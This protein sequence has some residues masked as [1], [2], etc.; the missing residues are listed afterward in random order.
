MIPFI[1]L[2]AQ[3]ALIKDKVEANFRRVLEHGQFIMGPEI[4][5]CEKRLADFAGARHCLTV[6][7]GTDALLVPLMALGVGPGDAVFVPSFTF[8]ATVEVVLLLGA[9]PVYVD[10]DRRTF[11]L[12]PAHLEA[13]IAAIRAEGKVRPRAVISVDLFGLPADYAAL[14]GICQDAE[15]VLIADAAQSFGGAIGN[16]RVGTLAPIT[17][18]SFFPAKPLGCYGDGG[19]VFTD[20]D[21]LRQTMASIRV[22]GQGK[23]KYELDRIGLNARFDTMQAAVILAKLDIFEDELAK[24][25]I[26]AARYTGA[27]DG[28]VVTPVV[29]DNH[30]S[31]WAQYT[32]QTDRRDALAAAL[33]DEGIPSAI[34]YPIPMHLQKVYRDYGDGEGS[35]PASEALAKCVLSLPMHPYLDAATIERIAGAVRRAA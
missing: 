22:H 5:A 23:S 1:D 26:V 34:Y 28:A 3:H 13:Q 15:L 35:C 31:A 10:V 12:D 6:S 33:K 2:K 7:S 11:N 14:N 19:A 27:L 32:I 24:R 8:T 4:A 9:R 16:K 25:Q 21:A 30:R 17:A 20:D 18:T 29:P